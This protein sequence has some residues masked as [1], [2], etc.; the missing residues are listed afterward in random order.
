MA[1]SDS[2]TA[3]TI[4]VCV[5]YTLDVEQVTSDPSTGRPV[6]S[7]AGRRINTFDLNGIEAGLRLRDEH[8]GRVVGVTLVA[9]RP[10]ENVVFQGL[11]MGLDELHLAIGDAAAATDALGTATALAQAIHRLGPVDLVICS[12][13]SVDEYRGEVGPRLAESLGLPCV[14]YVTGL[15]LGRDRLRAERT[16]ESVIETVEVGLPAVVSVGSETNDPRMPNLRAIRAARSKPVEEWALADLPGA[17]AA[18]AA[19]GERIATVSVQAPP[20]ERRH[21]VVDGKTSEETASTLLRHLLEDGA[22]RL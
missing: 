16:L 14:T 22:V 11:S 7:R 10:P 3:P 1:E 4:A 9:E 17:E 18:C 21:V 20:S 2:P 19:S 6:L 15:T 5:K 13:T 12:D 8:G